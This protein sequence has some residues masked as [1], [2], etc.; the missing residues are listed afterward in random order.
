MSQHILKLAP[1]D[2]LFFKDGR[3]MEG[4][5]A[6]HGAAWPLPHVLD[7][8]LHHALRRAKFE[9]FIP[10]A[11]TVKRS[12]QELN[13]DR[14][15][16]GR[17]FG[18]LQSAGPF[19]VKADGTWLFPRPADADAVSSSETTH[20]PLLDPPAHTASSLHPGLKPVVNT[21]P[22]NKDK[23][24]KWL[25]SE[26]YQ[27]YLD[28]PGLD[29]SDS[30]RDLSEETLKVRRDERAKNFLGDESI[31]AAEHNIGIGTN[32]ETGTQDGERI[33]SASYLR[34]KED[35]RIGLIAQCLDKGKGGHVAETDLIEK[36]FLNSGHENHILAGGQQ[37]TCTVLREHAESLPL[38]IGPAITGTRVRWT[39]LT[40]AIFPHLPASE[41][42]PTEHPGG[43]LPT[44]IHPQTL[45]IQ[46]KDPS[47]RKPPRH[48][49]E[50]RADYRRRLHRELG[51]NID[52]TLVAAVIPKPLPVTGWALTDTDQDNGTLISTGGARATHLA[53]PAGSVYY[54]ECGSPEAAQA[55]AAALN[56]HGDLSQP[57][58][59][60]SQPI[61]NR[62]STLFGEKGYGLGVCSTWTPLPTH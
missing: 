4:S 53:V 2:V 13:T 24:E 49:G 3:P 36:T 45:A 7:S 40:P 57:S 23:A 52:A 26:A 48:K 20:R 58:T 15:G 29:L 41:N 42:N 43:W 55:L 34:L 38:P 50:A 22:P 61:R 27:A 39:L 54:F 32:P 14:E 25:S 18:S 33:Y 56:W 21:R 1:T 30:L 5:S 31:F 12:G 16:H 46:L 60:N 59:L 9:D 8:A 62:R 17:T 51:E 6:G 44:W 37:R 10:H 19:P 35:F 11:H 28:G 47:A